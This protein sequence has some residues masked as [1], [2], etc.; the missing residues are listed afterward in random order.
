MTINVLVADD[1][2][3]VR[4]G[5]RRLLEENEIINLV[6]EASDST[7]L[8]GMLGDKPCDILVTDFSMPGGQFKDGL[9]LIGYVRRYF[10]HVKIIVVTMLENL[11]ILRGILKLGVHSILSKLDEQS[12]IAEIVCVVADG[13]R[14]IPAGLACR[15]NDAN[16]EE[17]WGPDVPKLS[18][19]EVEVVRLFVSGMTIS[20]IAVK[21]NRSVKTVSSQKTNAMRKLG[22]ERDVDLYHYATRS[23]IA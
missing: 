17:A 20:E 13:S 5:I 12:H 18:G 14:Y 4:Y 21:L 10:P 16:A 3:I 7:E 1:H 22:L 11:A 23:G 2:P 8:V 9:F 15:L 19:R 6:G